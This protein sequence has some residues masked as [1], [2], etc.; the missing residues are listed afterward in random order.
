MTLAENQASAGPSTKQQGFVR[1]HWFDNT[2]R[3]DPKDF[4]DDLQESPLGFL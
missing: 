2:G 3:T 4:D 1:A